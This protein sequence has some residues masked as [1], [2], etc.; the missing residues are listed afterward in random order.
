MAWASSSLSPWFGSGGVWISRAYC[1][2]SLLRERRGI[3]SPRRTAASS[4]DSLSESGNTS[5][6]GDL[7]RHHLAAQRAELRGPP[8]RRAGPRPDPRGGT[9]RAVVAQLA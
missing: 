8:A 9:A 3:S 5:R 7:G 2:V 6:H 4:G 1:M